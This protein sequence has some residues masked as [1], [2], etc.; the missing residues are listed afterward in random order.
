VAAS[1]SSQL[2]AAAAAWID[3]RL[4][5]VLVDA[6]F[7]NLAALFVHEGDSGTQNSGSW[8][9][10]GELQVPSHNIGERAPISLTL[11]HSGD[12]FVAT[13]RGV[14]RQ[15][16]QDGNIAAASA[17]SLSS[18]GSGDSWQAA[19]GLQHSTKTDSIAHLHM[20]AT[21]TSFARQPRLITSTL[22]ALPKGH[23][24]SLFFQ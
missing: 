18:I 1:G 14:W 4:H 21:A 16:L 11:T 23:T 9:P 22:A 13:S 7:P 3:G 5:A 8:L 2:L 10:V 15:R 6:S 24:D 17:G 12:L 20:E 19:C